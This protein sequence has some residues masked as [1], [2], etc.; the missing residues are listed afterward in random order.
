MKK[1]MMA[2]AVVVGMA[3]VAQAGGLYRLTAQEEAAKGATHV[4]KVT[5]ADLTATGTNGTAQTVTTL[6]PVTAK[7]A[8]ECV[9]AVLKTP[10]T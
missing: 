7:Q 4:V 8:V 2:M 5:H 10:F 6:F 3:L 1:L 9:M